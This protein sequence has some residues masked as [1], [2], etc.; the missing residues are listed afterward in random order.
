MVAW[1]DE[2]V[3]PDD[4][5]PHGMRVAAA[6]GWRLLVLLLVAYVGL[7]IV[8][9]LEFV[10]VALF[11]ALIISALVGPLVNALGAYVPR[12]PAVAVGLVAV[13]AGIVGV[14]VFIGTQ[15][16]GQ[17]GGLAIQFRQ[18][19]DEIL[20]WLENGPLHLT[21]AAITEYA[22][23]ARA[24]ITAH[25]SDLATTALGA[26]G[27]IVEFFTG[28]ALAVFA[29][30]FFLLGG[31]EIWSWMVGLFP[32]RQRGRI[33]G[34]GQVAWGSFAGYTRGIVVVAFVNAV[35][36]L[37][38]L[39]V[40]R[41]PLAFP[42]ALLVF[43]FSFIPLIGAPIATATAAVVA[44]A[45]RGPWIALA[46]VVLI[47]LIGQFEGH[48][49]QPLVMSK[50]V[51]LHPLAVGVAVASGTVLA[52]IVGAVIAVPLVAVLYSSIRF[53]VNTGSRAGFT[54][55]PTDPTGT[56]AALP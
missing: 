20:L 28:F 4:E 6:F 52:G 8:I 35:L 32:P 40:L 48:V 22:N 39:L 30:V 18:G 41:V 53:W 49:L 25:Q 13:V 29:S 12:G 11:V 9:A 55:P 17:W 7:R 24:W 54:P 34:V 5:I 26:S 3:R 10:A 47:V 31:R 36:V 50:A 21:T 37:V 42:L 27:T 14:F 1:H 15:V 56:G 38:G 16:A 44:L 45:A 33:D 19:M 2:R 46:V 23:T 43:L 51:H